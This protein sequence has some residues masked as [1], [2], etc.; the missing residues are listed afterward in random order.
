MIVII[1]NNNVFNN[2]LKNLTKKLRKKDE[3]NNN[4]NQ[5]LY[6]SK[7]LYIKDKD[8]TVYMLCLHVTTSDN[9]YA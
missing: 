7:I 1:V 4:E 5:C 6:I 9:L 2:V 3:K 8:M